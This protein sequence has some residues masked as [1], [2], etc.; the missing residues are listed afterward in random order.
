MAAHLRSPVGCGAFFSLAGWLEGCWFGLQDE[1]ELLGGA[2]WLVGWVV[3]S[4]LDGSVDVWES[5]VRCC[6]L[7][8]CS[9]QLVM[10][11]GCYAC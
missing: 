10:G 8:C 2:G 5:G 3:V 1:V 6:E 9:S 11:F 4:F 7:T